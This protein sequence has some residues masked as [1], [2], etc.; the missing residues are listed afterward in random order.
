M[1]KQTDTRSKDN[2][3]IVIWQNT[4][5]KV[6]VGVVQRLHQPNKLFFVRLSNCPEHAFASPYS[7]KHRSLRTD[8]GTDAHNL[9]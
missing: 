1:L 6:R 2:L 9:R 3:L 7:N 4:A 5:H 8:R